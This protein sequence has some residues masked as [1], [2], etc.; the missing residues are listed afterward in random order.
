MQYQNGYFV[1]TTWVTVD[2]ITGSISILDLAYL[3]DAYNNE[4]GMML[5]SNGTLFVYEVNYDSNDVASI[6]SISTETLDLD[7]LSCYVFDRV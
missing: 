5:L 6:S 2:F 7:D 4:I 1:P 3:Y